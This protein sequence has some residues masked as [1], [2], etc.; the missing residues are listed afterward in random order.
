MEVPPRGRALRRQ[1]SRFPIRMPAPFSNLESFRE[2]LP[3]DLVDV[4][5]VAFSVEDRSDFSG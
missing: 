2:Y 3:E 5:Q 1:K 4:F